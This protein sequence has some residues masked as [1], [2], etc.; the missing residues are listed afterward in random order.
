M[1]A[2][3]Y[4]A[5]RIGSK[6]W[7]YLQHRP[8]VPPWP[9]S[10]RNTSPCKYLATDRTRL[11]RPRTR[12]NHRREPVRAGRPPL[13][14]SKSAHHCRPRPT[15]RLKRTR[16][17]VVEALVADRWRL[18]RAACLVSVTFFPKGPKDSLTPRMPLATPSWTLPSPK[19]VFGPLK[20]KT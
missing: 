12:S 15:T 14:R 2:P 18:D 9:L 1:L 3:V 4:P 6:V 5:R 8:P 16:A 17:N 20:L 10:C 7:I 11:R 19:A 13:L